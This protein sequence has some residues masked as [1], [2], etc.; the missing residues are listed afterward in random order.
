MF[1]PEEFSFAKLPVEVEEY[2]DN[3]LRCGNLIFEL[4]EKFYKHKEKIA[5]EYMNVGWS[6][7]QIRA[8]GQPNVSEYWQLKF[9]K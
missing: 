1:K 4:P 5:A 3:Q 9:T 8:A 6:N 2:I 7:V